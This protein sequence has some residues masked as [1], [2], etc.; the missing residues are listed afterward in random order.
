MGRGLLVAAFLWMAMLA[1][2]L[3]KLAGEIER[4]TARVTTLE[5]PK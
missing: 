4:L 5:I 2:S 1:I 3:L